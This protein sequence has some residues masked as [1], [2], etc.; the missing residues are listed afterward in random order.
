MNESDFLFDKEHIWH[1]YTSLIAPLP[2]IGVVA[3]N[4]VELTLHDGTKLIDGM[5]SWWSTIHGYNHPR[6]NQAAKDQIDNMSHVMFGGITHP[7]AISLCRRLVDMTTPKLDRVFLSDSGSVAVEVALKMAIQYWVAKEQSNKSK[8]LTI[9]H[10]YHGD[11]FAAMSVCDPV[12]GMHDLFNNVLT[13]QLFAKA[14]QVGFDEIWND[15]DIAPLSALFEAHHHHAAAIILEPIVQ[16][17]GGMRMYH[18]NYLKAVRQLCDKYDVLLICDE[19][20]TGFGRTGKMFAYEHANITPDILC[21]G[22]ALTGGYMSL[23]A[24]MTSQVIGET[25]CKTK[26][27]VFMHGPTFMGNPL[28]CAVANESLAMLQENNWQAQV[29]SIEVQLKELFKKFCVLENVANT[30]VLG[31]IG[32]IELIKPVDMESIQ[33]AF[34]KQGIWV[35][36]FGKLVYIMPQYIITP[37]QLTTLCNGIYN[38]VANLSQ[39]QDAPLI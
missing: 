25:I 8:M 37:S 32:V 6:L 35:R 20:A 13:K 5:S 14:P 11:T 18:P 33:A 7:S 3:A 1:P 26:A 10:G 28:A 4:G 12:N 29:L 21:V 34:V 9:E 36:P 27:G 31:A 19:I 23:A 15:D 38:V 17:A 39:K 16:G 30:R 24:T 2:C 22:K